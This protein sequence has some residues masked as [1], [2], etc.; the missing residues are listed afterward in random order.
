MFKGIPVMYD[1]TLD[2]LSRAK[3]AYIW[4]S[5][6]IMLYALEGDWKRQR[7]PARPYNNFVFY[8]SMLCTGQMCARRRNSALVIEIA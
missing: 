1:P 3:Y 2:D 5:R 4:D 7:T 6:D 8:Q